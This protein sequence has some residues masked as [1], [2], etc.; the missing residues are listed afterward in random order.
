MDPQDHVALQLHLAALRRMRQEKRLLED[1]LRASQ[2]ALH[3]K[4]RERALLMGKKQDMLAEEAAKEEL[5]DN[6]MVFI[7]AIENNDPEIAQNFDEQAMMEILLPMMNSHGGEGDGGEGDSSES[8]EG[9]GSDG[10][11]CDSGA[12][13]GGEGGEGDGSDGGEGDGR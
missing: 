10:S 8:G 3:K 11:E 12:V 9:D 4:E 2:V 13:A 7:G 1:S 5:V 6:F